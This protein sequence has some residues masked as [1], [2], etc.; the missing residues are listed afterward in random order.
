MSVYNDEKYIGEAIESI[1]CQTFNDFE[2]IIIDDCSSDESRSIISCHSKKDSRIIIHRNLN[3][4]GLGYSLRKSIIMSRGELIARMDADDISVPERLDKQVHFFNKHAN[5]SILGTAAIDIDENGDKLRNRNVPITHEE[6]RQI[7]PWANPMVHTSVMFRKADILKLGSYSRGL[8]KLQDY[9]L[10]F[11][12]ISK[13]FLFANLDEPLVF[14]RTGENYYQ[15]KSWSY[16]IEDV[17]IRWNGYKIINEK[18]IKRA[19]V[20]IPVL[21]G[22]LPLWL[23]PTAYKLGKKLD[24]RNVKWNQI[25]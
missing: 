11:R 14:Y 13:N 18:K 25:Y 5:I 22:I 21:L 12:A 17:K 16:R 24:P 2:F 3:Q 19:G 6:I 23:A 9:E 15:K 8:P 1:L 4:M 10:W 20:I 7:L